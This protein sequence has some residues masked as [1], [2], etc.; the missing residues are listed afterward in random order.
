[1]RIVSFSGIDGAGKSTQIAALEGWLRAAGVRT[2]VVT[3]WDE[4][5]VLSRFRESA[6]HK[7]FGGDKGIGTPEQPI[8][9]RD[10]NV[11]SWTVVAARFFLYTLDAISL[12][13]QLRRI[14]KSNTEVVI[15]DR[16][17]YDEL[18]NLPLH[19]L[20]ARVFTG[21]ILQFTPPPDA[22]YVIDADPEQARARKPEYPLE[23][24]RQNREAYLAL[25]RMDGRMIV[26]EA[27]SI[28]ATAAKIRASFRAEALPEQATFSAVPAS[29]P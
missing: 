15:F 19:N 23:F 27:S 4:V 29:L 21:W 5:V 6:S 28:P 17:I 11:S 10:K 7:A 16:Y 14:N 12:R 25:S 13:L 26:T 22:A 1:V 9:R 20:L 18:A 24:L 8:H 3:F 2:R